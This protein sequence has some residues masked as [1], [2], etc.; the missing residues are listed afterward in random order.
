MRFV[1]TIDCDNAAFGDTQAERNR[2]T[3]RLLREV[4]GRV[5]GLT[6]PVATTL[7]EGRLSDANGNTVGRFGF[8]EGGGS[9]GRLL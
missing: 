8:E 7:G 2:E 4:A 1:L 6:S 5:T 3:A 9:V